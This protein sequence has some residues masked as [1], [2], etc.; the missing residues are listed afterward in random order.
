MRIMF[1]FQST[2]K[3]TLV[4]LSPLRAQDE[5]PERRVFTVVVG[6]AARP[7][8]FDVGEE[9]LIDTDGPEPWAHQGGRD[10]TDGTEERGDADIQH[11]ERRPAIS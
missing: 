10:D 11:H 2:L 8:S 5:R 7:F 6:V 4:E 1:D 3:G 9:Q